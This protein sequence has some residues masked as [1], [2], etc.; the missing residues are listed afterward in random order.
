M[1]TSPYPEIEKAQCFLQFIADT[2]PS[3]SVSFI[4]Q[5]ASKHWYKAQYNENINYHTPQ[6]RIFNSILRTFSILDSICRHQQLPHHLKDVLVEDAKDFI[7]GLQ[8]SDNIM[9]GIF[10]TKP[11]HHIDIIPMKGVLGISSYRGY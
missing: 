4:T 9:I 11:I 1:E 5:M 6:N 8:A 2:L 7:V 10:K 3:M